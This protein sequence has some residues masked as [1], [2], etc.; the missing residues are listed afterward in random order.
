MSGYSVVRDYPHSQA[1]VW[2][3]VTD[4]A[5]I[6]LWTATGAGGRTEGFAATVGTKFQ[7][8]AKPRPG[9]SGVV[10]CEVLEANE[11]SLLRYSWA[12]PSGGGTSEVL[13][14]LEPL[15][16]GTRFTIEHT[17]FTGAGGFFVAKILGNVRAKMLTVGLPAVLDDLD[18]NGML[19]ATST[20]AP[21][22]R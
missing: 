21:K 15:G 22:P 8:I 17:G 19:R 4:P 11:P 3:A 7:F 18:D 5:L 9:W 20:L 16:L 13:Y 2:R 6:P 12:D 14:R 10:D 1:K